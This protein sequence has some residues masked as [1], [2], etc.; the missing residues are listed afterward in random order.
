M[1]KGE[2]VAFSLHFNFRT[3]KIELKEEESNERKLRKN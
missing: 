3:N 1:R 2:R